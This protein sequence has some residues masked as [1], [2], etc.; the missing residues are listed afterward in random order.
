MQIDTVSKIREFN[1]F[2][3]GLLGVTNNHILESPY[4]LTEVR[5]MFEIYHNPDITARQIKKIVQVDE[6]YLSRLI[7]KLVKQKIV[8]KTKSKK[9]SR[10]FSLGLSKNGERIFLNLNQKSSDAIAKTIA[11]LSKGE[12]E[13]LVEHLSKIKLLITKNSSGGLE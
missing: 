9:D 4:S 12:Q 1:R 10:V 3:T 13:E 11:H 6:G 2:Y 8:I 7:T 5:V